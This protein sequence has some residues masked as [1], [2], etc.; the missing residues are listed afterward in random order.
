MPKDC[1]RP[2]AVLFIHGKKKERQHDQDHHNGCQGHVRFCLQKKK[3]RQSDEDRC[4]EADELPLCQ[5]Q[6]DLAFD[7][8]QVTGH[9]GIKV[10]QRYSF[11]AGQPAFVNNQ[12]ALKM[13]L[14]MDPVLKR[15]NA[16]MREYKR[17]SQTFLIRCSDAA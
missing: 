3:E 4:P 17:I 1:L 8:C 2:L 15:P 16:S 13:D 7:P 9:I 12:W 10:F 11:P 14:L 5:V 6:E